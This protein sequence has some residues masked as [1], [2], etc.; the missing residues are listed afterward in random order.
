MS[1]TLHLIPPNRTLKPWTTIIS[2]NV[3]EHYK[4]IEDKGRGGQGKWIDMILGLVGGECLGWGRAG[5]GGIVD[6]LFLVVGR[7]CKGILLDYILII[8]VLF[9]ICSHL[10]LLI[11]YYYL[12]YLYYYLK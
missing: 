6:A 8:V 10:L 3:N 9:Y 7:S 11:N 12:Y 4:Y 2:I 5:L 1:T